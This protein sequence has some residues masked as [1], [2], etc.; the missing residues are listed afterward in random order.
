MSR[1]EK[2]GNVIATLLLGNTRDKI[3]ETSVDVKYIRKEIDED[4]KPVIK[5]LDKRMADLNSK[6]VILWE[7]AFAP[8]GVF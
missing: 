6:M 2:I 1:L 8:P 5:D 7:R 4:I 3:I